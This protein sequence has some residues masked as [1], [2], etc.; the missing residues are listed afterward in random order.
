MFKVKCLW[1]KLIL[2]TMMSFNGYAANNSAGIVIKKGDIIKSTLSNNEVHSYDLKLDKGQFVFGDAVQLSVDLKVS[3]YTPDGERLVS[4]DGPAL[5]SELFQF[6]SE[7]AGTYQIKVSPYQ[8]A[9]GDYSLQIKHLEPIATTAK[10]KVEQLMYGYNENTPGAV[11]AIANKGKLEYVQAF[12]MANV[13]YDITNKS[14]TPFHMASVSKQFTAFAIVLL[15]Q[16]GKLSLDDDIRKFLPELPKFD[17]R[18]TVRNLLNHTSG[19]RDH[20]NLWTMSGGRMDDVIRQDDLLR[21]VKRQRELNFNPGDEHLYSNTGYL[22]LSEIVSSIT[23]EKFSDWMK[24]NVFQPLG[25][26]S[27][28][29]Y[30]NHERI[31]KN[32]AY[33]YRSSGAGLA[34]SVLSYANSGATSLFSTAEDLALWLDNFRT[35]KVG[36]KSAIDQLQEQAVLNNGKT[37]D[38]ALGVVIDDDNGLK[39]ISHGGADA[40]FRTYLNYYP[41]LNSGLI[42]L[43][44]TASMRVGLIKQDI[45]SAFFGDHMSMTPNQHHNAQPPHETNKEAE[46]WTPTPEEL[47]SYEGR[48][49][50]DELET[51]YTIAVDGKRLKIMHRRHGESY[52]AVKDK[53]VF[54]SSLWFLGELRF[55]RSTNGSINQ[56]NMTNGRVRNLS[57]KKVKSISTF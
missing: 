51:F 7:I 21:L 47:I 1:G 44:N 5:G 12:G 24:N 22:L 8:K 31:V 48:Y 45:T 10:G 20:W 35:G 53:D 39:E 34:K 38:Y 25:M 40:G 26:N 15:A 33:S 2:V 46:K 19:L 56:V 13:E 27:T 4:F 9:E 54:Q 42:I 41:E 43:A 28:Q 32:R 36:G 50:S 57:F 52:L 37:I 30:D 18:I 3:I 17:H 14:T 29:I 6:S 49:Y 55:L 23:D 11:V 16:D